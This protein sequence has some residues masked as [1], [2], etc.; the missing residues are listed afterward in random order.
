MAAQS[1]IPVKSLRKDDVKFLN[2]KLV[3]ISDHGS[4]DGI[5]YINI[6][7]KYSAT[8]KKT[9]QS[10]FWS[11]SSKWGILL[12]PFPVAVSALATAIYENLF[13]P[14]VELWQYTHTRHLR[15]RSRHY[16]EQR[17]AQI[18]EQVRHIV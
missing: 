9:F 6:F 13:Q 7:R 15:H 1:C 14:S 17:S 4:S 10:A 2:T 18:A 16:N 5:R 12:F 11:L 8:E 3:G